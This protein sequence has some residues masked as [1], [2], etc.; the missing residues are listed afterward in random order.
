[1]HQQVADWLRQVHKIDMWIKKVDDTD[2]Y[3]GEVR[4]DKTV[5]SGDRLVGYGL[6]DDHYESYNK[7]L[8]MVL[9]VY[10]KSIAER[11]GFDKLPVS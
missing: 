4:V 2:S 10:G 11:M 9:D 8:G 6:S 7:T 5:Y 1:M 3:F